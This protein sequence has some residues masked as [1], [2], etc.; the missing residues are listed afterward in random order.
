LRCGAR[1]GV[2]DFL[3]KEQAGTLGVP[4]FKDD[5]GETMFLSGAALTA[6][7][8]AASVSPVPAPG[9]PS[10]VPHSGPQT[11]VIRQLVECDGTMYAAGLFNT[12][13][14]HGKAYSR[15]GAFS[16]SARSPY[17]MT[18][19]NPDVQGEVN[20][21]ALAD[22]CSRAWLG[23]TMGLIEVST[24]T[25]RRVAGFRPDISDEVDTVIDWHGHL[26]TGGDF[27]GYYFSLNPATGRHDGFLAGL[28]IHGSEPPG[29]YPTRVHNQQLSPSGRRML[30][31]GNF[32]RVAGHAR[33]QIFMLN[34]D[35]RP[36]RLTAWYSSEFN[37][38]CIRH[39]SFYI[40]SAA[41]SP[42]GSRVYIASTGEHA[43]NWDRH[44]P[45]IGLCDVVAAFPSTW[46][47]VDNIWRNFTGCDSLYSVAAT[48]SAVFAGGHQRWIDNRDGCNG[49]G[50]GAIPDPGLEGLTTAGAPE[51]SAGRAR[52]T[53][54]KAN[55]DDMLITGAGLWIAS[56]NR[57]NS[58]TCG[59]AVGHSGICLLPAQG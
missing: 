12:I 41:W 46:K 52:Y 49:P 37:G 17:Q 44:S 33:R 22:H 15:H 20:S 7:T 56:T 18:S 10:L 48:A 54:S 53:M 11:A 28:D 42:D 50:P 58:D 14:S 8:A 2:E 45:Q 5:R 24:S 30:V 23:G 26:L 29:G 57:F 39:E 38:Q 6:L 1:G 36:A 25:G 3:C 4:A 21:I 35:A 13:S 59:P 55:A 27:P 19:W 9:T 31:E 43:L 51:L 34:L 32:T 40:R 16:F 47:P